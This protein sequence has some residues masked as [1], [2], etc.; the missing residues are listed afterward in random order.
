MK[1][2]FLA[3]LLA[4]MSQWTVAETPSDT[5][6]NDAS[7]TPS[8][9][10]SIPSTMPNMMPE[11][12]WKFGFTPYIWF[13]ELDATVGPLPEVPVSQNQFWDFF[14]MGALAEFTAQKGKIGLT[15]HLVYFR[16]GAEDDHDDVTKSFGSAPITGN[17]LATVTLSDIQYDGHVSHLFNSFTVS[18]LFNEE[19]NLKAFTGLRHDRVELDVELSA[20]IQV[21][22][23]TP[24]DYSLDQNESV[25]L[26]SWMFGFGT[27]S[28][29]AD[30]WALSFKTFSSLGDD[31]YTFEVQGMVHWEMSEH[32]ETFFGGL[33]AH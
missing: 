4:A 18:Y 27:K 16:L 29:I 22:S 32:W 15:Y 11:E 30:D 14:E 10:A 24:I 7:S 17:P 20:D 19:H 21:N 5:P 13:V 8:T 26:F 2:I 31:I 12:E 28:P 25:D 6:T 1:R 33:V 3:T 23:G 9:E